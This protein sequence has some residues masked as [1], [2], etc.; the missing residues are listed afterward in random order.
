MDQSFPIRTLL[1]QIRLAENIVYVF[2]VLCSKKRGIN[3][4]KIFEITTNVNNIKINLR[5]DS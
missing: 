1:E 5:K 4:K 2:I 3:Y